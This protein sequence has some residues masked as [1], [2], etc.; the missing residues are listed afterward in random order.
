MLNLNMSEK[1]AHQLTVVVEPLDD[2][3]ALRMTWQQNVTYTD[4]KQ[5][6]ADIHKRL[7]ESATPLYVIVDI[8]SH[9]KFPLSATVAEAAAGPY[10][11]PKLIEWL[12]IGSDGMARLIANLLGALTGRRNVKW[13]QSEAEVLAYMEERRIKS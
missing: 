8:S 4:L 2:E 9:P 12:V 3:P 11:N 5:A 7:N 13:F 1:N 10:R 6:F